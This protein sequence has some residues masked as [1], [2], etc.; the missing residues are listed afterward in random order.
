MT[1]DADLLSAFDVDEMAPEALLF[2]NGYLTIM[3]EKDE[4]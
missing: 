4:G 1:V 2:Q 3:G